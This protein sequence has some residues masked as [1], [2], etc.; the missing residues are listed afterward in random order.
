MKPGDQLKRR[1][2]MDGDFIALKA[3]R[4]VERHRFPRTNFASCPPGNRLGNRA[5]SRVR[6]SKQ[7][8][9]TPKQ[10]IDHVHFR[11]A[12]ATNYGGRFSL[13]HRHF[14]WLPACVLFAS[15]W[16]LLPDRVV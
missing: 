8:A 14:L 1:V 13:R 11:G 9:K 16:G 12:T 6:S 5:G 2:K 10:K 3:D 7:F 15:K 4:L